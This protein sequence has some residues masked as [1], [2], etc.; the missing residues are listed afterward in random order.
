[1]KLQQ[2]PNPYYK[3]NKKGITPI[4]KIIRSKQSI[5]FYG[6]IFRNSGRHLGYQCQWQD[7]SHTIAYLNQIKK[8][9]K[10]QKAQKHI[11]LIWDNASWHKSKKVKQWL[12]DNPGIVELMNFPPYSPDLNPQEHVWKKLRQY[13]STASETHTFSEIVDKACFFLNTN[14]F[15]YKLI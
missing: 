10:K 12:K 14:C 2:E 1:M 5:S 13:L 7:S 15:K 6:G 9:H 11:L 8:Y 4:D 3:W